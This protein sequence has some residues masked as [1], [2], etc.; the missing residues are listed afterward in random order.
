MSTTICRDPH[1]HT[2]TENSYRDPHPRVI[3]IPV[4]LFWPLFWPLSPYHLIIPNPLISP[5][6]LNHHTI[7]AMQCFT[8]V[9]PQVGA[10]SRPC[11]IP[12]A[13]VW[14]PSLERDSTTTE[15]QFFS[16]S[17]LFEY[18]CSYFCHCEITGT[19][20]SM[21]P[22]CSILPVILCTQSGAPKP[23]PISKRSFRPRRVMKRILCFPHFVSAQTHASFA[24]SFFVYI[25]FSLILVLR[26]PYSI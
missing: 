25:S 22:G 8:L 13:V 9:S 4:T 18:W 7:T 21:P 2:H 15:T 26:F 23:P 16:R 19:V 10:I 12:K 6:R 20:S 1:P 24:R 14:I 5:P 11:V 3:Y 17:C